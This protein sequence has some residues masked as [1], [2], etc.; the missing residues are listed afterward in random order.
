MQ[1]TRHDE[2]KVKNT[3]K[4]IYSETLKKTISNHENYKNAPDLNHLKSI[5]SFNVKQI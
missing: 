5:F 3:V 4:L 1:S 2:A